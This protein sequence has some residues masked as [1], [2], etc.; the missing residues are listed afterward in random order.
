MIANLLM[1]KFLIFLYEYFLI[2]KN[3]VNCI[4]SKGENSIE[5]SQKE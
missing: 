1:M 3:N 5:F 4:L 2:K